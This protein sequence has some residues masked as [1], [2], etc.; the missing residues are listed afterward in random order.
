MNYYKNKEDDKEH[1]FGS[2]LMSPAS[3]TSLS[4][5]MM[6]SFPSIG[7]CCFCIIIMIIMSMSH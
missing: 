7:C 5:S 2:D 6:S 1:M 4:P 3:S